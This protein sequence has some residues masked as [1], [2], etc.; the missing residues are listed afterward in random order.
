MT[1]KEVYEAHVKSLPTGRKPGQD[2]IHLAPGERLMPMPTRYCFN[3]GC[4]VGDDHSADNCE[5]PR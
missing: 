1:A 3:C 4:F 5:G 2:I